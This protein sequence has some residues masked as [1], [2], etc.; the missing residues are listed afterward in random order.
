[1]NL[2]SKLKH[3]YSNAKK[4]VI[5]NTYSFSNILLHVLLQMIQITAR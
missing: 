3:T 5:Q 4:S 1:M 2:A